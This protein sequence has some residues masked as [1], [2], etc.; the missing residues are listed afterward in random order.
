[1]HKVP[2]MVIFS[3][4]VL[5]AS[6]VGAEV[7]ATGESGNADFGWQPGFHHEDLDARVKVA[8]VFDDGGGHALFVGGCFTTAGSATVNHIAKRDG[9][10]WT[11]LAGPSAVG[12][13]GVNEGDHVEV[14]ALAVF[15]DGG[16]PALYVGGTFL[17]AG[18][19]S[20]N[21]IA[22][23][24]GTQWSD[25]AG[26]S[27]IG[28]DGKVWALAVYDDGGGE[29]LYVAG[30]FATA[31][32]ISVN[33][34]AKWD[35]TQWSVLGGTSAP[36]LNNVVWALAVFDGSLYVGGIFTEA[37]GVTVNGIA[38]WDGASW[39]APSGPSGTGMNGG[40]H[41]LVVYDDGTGAALFA[42]G[43]FSTAGGVTVNRISKWDGVSWSSLSGPLGT[44]VGGGF[45][46]VNSL[47]VYD[48]GSGPALFVGGEFTTAG[49]GVVNQ[50]ARW[51]GTS[52]SALD[53]PSGTGMGGVSFPRV[54]CLVVFDPGTGDA[55]FAGGYFLSAG[56]VGVN[57]LA[58][59]DG[60]SWSVL[61]QPSGAGMSYFVAALESY[62]DGAGAMLYAGGDFTRAG[63][64]AAG[65]IAK[66]NGSQ[67]S[68]LAGLSGEGMNGV[69]RA[70][71]VYDDGGGQAL[72]AGGDFTTAAGIAADRV[73][74]WDGIDW[75]IP[76]G[77]SAGGM[78]GLILAFAVYGG[79]TG[80]ALYA[81]G[82][83]ETAGG[84]TVNHI[85][86][87]DGSGWSALS[88]SSGF[89]TNDAVHALVVF[90][91]GTGS[92]LYAGGSFTEAGGQPAK[93][94][95][96]WDGAEWSALGVLL[97][98]GLY[99]RVSALAVFDDGSGPALFAG[100][101]F[102]IA[103]GIFVDNI[104]KWN[105]TQWSA[106]DGSFGIGTD[107]S[108]RAL[109]V[110]DDGSG[111]ALYAGGYF[112]TAGGVRVN[113]I[114]RWDGNRWLPLSAPLGV[115]IDGSYGDYD[116]AVYTLGVFNDGTG[117]AL[118]AG[119]SFATAGGVP[120]SRIA[121]WTGDPQIF[122]DGFE[123]EDTSMWSVVQP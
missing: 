48:D 68:A 104:A 65:R 93:Y 22:K 108:V 36:G 98:D 115:G 79:G 44:G 73:A 26:P 97:D 105:G 74:K 1:M 10:G 45:P 72:Y 64:A 88:G 20:V 60:A 18:G 41:G 9:A 90:D 123:T 112:E 63:V 70:L 27:G 2:L 114:A 95:A 33:N 40:V 55:L 32:G 91:D 46:W 21:N 71:A 92:A 59:W 89:G 34:I 75:S 102:T 6:L 13:D 66:W 85:G 110:Y 111:N 51:D 94:I 120:S 67:W 31:G 7:S 99:G 100:G 54:D 49:G 53:G 23:W 86:G 69:V 43:T 25:F 109:A 8:T 76:G 116:R 118:F 107:G 5:M 56:G 84:I 121:K 87:W 15:D 82:S 47:A 38:K 77:P 11:A 29:A 24:D 50:I 117:N 62:D 4:L 3:T 39:S 61:S 78:D 16:G 52:W 17:T 57:H 35:G 119:G 81:G 42:G 101:N 12:V 28:I 122:A 19:I 106:L 30:D 96:K 113:R 58:Q 83:F 80:T 37:D 103:D 14:D